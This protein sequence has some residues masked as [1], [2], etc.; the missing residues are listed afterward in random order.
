VQWFGR[1]PHGKESRCFVGSYRSGLEKAMLRG[2]EKRDA[3]TTRVK[4][5]TDAKASRFNKCV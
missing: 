4:A 2:R 1:V 5:A 3:E